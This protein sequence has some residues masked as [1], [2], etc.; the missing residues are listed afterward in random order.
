MLKHS[1][2]AKEIL[3]EEG[4]VITY[5]GKSGILN[6]LTEKEC[7]KIFQTLRFVK[8]LTAFLKYYQYN[9]R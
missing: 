8:I 2:H 3:L 9:F 7:T 1:S 4:Y 6:I 5:I